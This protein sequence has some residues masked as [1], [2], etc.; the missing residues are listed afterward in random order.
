M[1]RVRPTEVR[2]VAALLDSPAESVEQLATDVIAAI[3]E[4][5]AKR[6]DYVI[7]VQHSGWAP[8]FAAYGPYLTKTAAQ[9]DVGKSVIASTVGERYVILPLNSNIEEGVEQLL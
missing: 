9:K 7:V 8:F 5:R 2:A 1:P 6:T 3:D 4:L